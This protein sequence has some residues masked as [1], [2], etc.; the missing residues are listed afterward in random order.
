M[1]GSG[2]NTNLCYVGIDVA[3]QKFDVAILPE[4]IQLACPYDREGVDRLLARLEK[5]SCVIALEATGGLER[6]LAGELVAAGHQVAIVNPRQIR[7]FARGLG[8]LAKNDRVDSRV[9]AHYAQHARLRLVEKRS[10]KQDELTG[11]VVRRRQLMA[12]QTTE[13][14]RLE[15]TTAKS[16]IKSIRHV[17]DLLRKELKKLDEEIAALIQADDDWRNKSELL[18]SV[19]GVGPGTSAS[20]V[21]ELPELGKLNRQQI[22]SLVGVAPFSHD[23]GRFRGQRSI[24]GGRASVRSALYMAAF[25]ARRCNPII[26]AFADRLQQAGKRPKVI[27]V[28]CMRKLLVILNTMVRNQNTWT[29]AHAPQNT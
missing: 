6:R 10:E 2:N 16:A 25:N 14:N 15:L 26:R 29:P 7:D 28:A 21:A 23:S 17:L 3:K 19:P 8:I 4:D 24:W 27:L 11:L 20:L 18:Q 13:S 9:L 5:Q 22:A 1:D 12:L